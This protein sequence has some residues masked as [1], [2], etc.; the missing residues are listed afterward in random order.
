[1]DCLGTDHLIHIGIGAA[2]RI[3]SSA[4][5]DSPFIHVS[6]KCVIALT[7]VLVILSGKRGSWI[8]FFQIPFQPRPFHSKSD[9]CSLMCRSLHYTCQ[10]KMH[11]KPKISAVVYFSVVVF[12]FGQ[13]FGHFWGKSFWHSTCIDR[14]AVRPSFLLVSWTERVLGNCIDS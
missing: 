1:M 13:P 8:F 14:G 5:K 4:T 12:C 7:L 9:G 2:V 11:R 3:C 10:L 6:T